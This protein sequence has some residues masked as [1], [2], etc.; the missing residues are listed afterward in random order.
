MSSIGLLP[1]LVV[2]AYRL[3]NPSLVGQTVAQ[4]EAR[5]ES[6][7]VYVDRL[8]LGGKVVDT[9]PDLVGQKRRRGGPGFLPG[10]AVGH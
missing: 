3:T 5:F 1:R 7:R 10:G 6:Q 2:R 4:I 8:R 9:K